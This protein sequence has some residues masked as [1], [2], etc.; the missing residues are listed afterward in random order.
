MQ[1]IGFWVDN[2]DN[3][4]IISRVEELSQYFNVVLFYN[5]SKGGPDLSICMQHGL[6]SWGFREPIIA[7]DEQ[8]AYYLE[9][10][11]YPSQKFAL[12][13]RLEGLQEI[14]NLEQDTIYEAIG[15]GK[16]EVLE[17]EVL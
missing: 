6:H 4:S 17:E 5:T 3:T 15:L 7:L 16:K 8:A 1:T 12:N 2:F 9:R 14:S 13:I 11:P 10:N